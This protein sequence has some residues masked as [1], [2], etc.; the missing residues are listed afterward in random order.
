MA[1]KLLEGVAGSGKSTYI[2]NYVLN[3]GV[4]DKTLLI[5]FSRTGREVLQKYI[6]DRNLD[7][8]HYA[9]HTIDGLATRL[10]VE[11]GDNYS[12]L[13]RDTIARELLPSLLD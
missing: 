1:A 9:I 3:Y 4:K 2:A 6:Q 11:L 8:S 10:L 7:P 5:T 13:K 12:V